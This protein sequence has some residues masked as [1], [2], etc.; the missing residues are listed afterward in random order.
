MTLPL[1]EIER[2]SVSFAAGREAD[3]RER[4]V[5]AVRDVSLTLARGETLALVG[6][7][8]CGK[9]TLARAVL[10]LVPNDSG[11]VSLDGVELGQLSRSQLR[12][13]RPRMQMV[14][15]DPQSSLN[16]RLNVAALVGEAML[17]HGHC[18]R[19]TLRDRVT[20]VLQKV[21]LSASHL[22]R[23]PHEFSGGQRQRI[24]IARA[25]ALNPD[26][27]VCDEAVAALDVSVQA[28][29]L[30][31]LRELQQ[32]RGLAYLFISHDL[33]V[34]RHVAHVVAVMYLGKI[35]EH[36]PAVAVLTRPQHPYTQALLA[37]S[38]EGENGFTQSY[39]Q[40]EVPS[41]LA[42][43]SGC[44]FHP[45]CKLA[46]ALCKREAPPVHGIT[47][48]VRVSCHFPESGA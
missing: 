42:P 10:Q 44:A 22:N 26:L 45:R 17:A 7:S 13:M 36:G 32:K 33:A 29:V 38:T 48:G 20:Q 24:G 5:Q 34:V 1:L 35:V 14:F 9:S 8:G 27:V 43:P 47:S 31:L 18:T 39:L 3:G 30:N 19:A 6:E 46:T 41:P 16:P 2:L 28:Q 23:Y 25:V 4:R 11:L 40:G 15:Q 37:C 21:G 12:A